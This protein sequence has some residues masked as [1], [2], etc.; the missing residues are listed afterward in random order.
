MKKSILTA[1]LF[2]SVI[3]AYSQESAKDSLLHYTG[4]YKFPDG[5]VVTEVT[6]TFSDSTLTMSSAIGSAPL[7]KMGG[8]EFELVGYNGTA[9]FKRNAEGKVNGVV[10]VVGDINI[11]GTKSEGPEPL[12][13]FRKRI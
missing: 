12:A 11:E 1:I 6:V 2:L 9:T 7:R 4:K 10:I 13:I 5:S 3:A 8:E